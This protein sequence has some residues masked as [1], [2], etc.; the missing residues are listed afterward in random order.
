M[1]RHRKSFRSLLEKYP[2]SPPCNCPVCLSYCIRPGWWTVAEAVRAIAAGYGS[3]MMLEMS[4]DQKY[5]VLSP[6]FKGCESEFAREIYSKAGCT[7]LSEDSCELH[8]TGFQ[9]LECRYCHHERIGLGSRCHADIGI[10][11]NSAAG[12]SLVVRWCKLTGLWQR[13]SL[14]NGLIAGK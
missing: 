5:G 8:G 11:W 4:P 1:S 3:R 6:A 10:D 12:R 14:L 13:M 7:F 2:A 9:P